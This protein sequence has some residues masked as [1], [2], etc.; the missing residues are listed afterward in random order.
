MSWSNLSKVSKINCLH[1]SSGGIPGQGCSAIQIK[2][3]IKFPFRDFI[4]FL[5]TYCFK[6]N[7]SGTIPLCGTG[8]VETAL[9]FQVKAIL[10]IS[11]SYFWLILIIIN[12]HIDN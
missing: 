9:L 10:F 5:I 12:I 6:S 4:D 3:K 1:A 8:C 7:R 11:L 2:R